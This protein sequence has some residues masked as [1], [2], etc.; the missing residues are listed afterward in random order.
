VV[1][2]TDNTIQPFK[3]VSNQDSIKSLSQLKK[4]D[5]SAKSKKLVDSP[6]KGD[7][8]FF[9][10][11]VREPEPSLDKKA[12]LANFKE[13]ISLI[14]DEIG[15]KPSG[16]NISPELKQTALAARAEHKGFAEGNTGKQDKLGLPPGMR[17]AGVLSSG[18]TIESMKK[19]MQAGGVFSSSRGPQEAYQPGGGSSSPAVVKLLVDYAEAI[20]NGYK[21]GEKTENLTQKV[22]NEAGKNEKPLKSMIGL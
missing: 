4:K 12:K 19:G 11:D 1:K 18:K 2:L 16:K 6:V 7:R 14:R 8:T 15:V 13:Q 3:N 20:K 17:S 5:E 22:L 21:I 10:D 9:S